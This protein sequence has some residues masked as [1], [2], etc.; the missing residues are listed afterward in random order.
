MIVHALMIPFVMVMLNVFVDGVPKM[1]F[2]NWNDSIQ[3]FI[4]DRTDES[5][6]KR[7]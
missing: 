1:G 3:A 2:T 4:L 6:T 5:F 7:I